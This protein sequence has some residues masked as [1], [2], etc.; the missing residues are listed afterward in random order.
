MSLSPSDL[1]PE[2]SPWD[3]Y[4]DRSRFLGKLPGNRK[5][6]KL[7][8]RLLRVRSNRFYMYSVQCQMTLLVNGGEGGGGGYTI[9]YILNRPLPTGAFQGQ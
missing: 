6:E 8:N 2:S 9:Q 5:Q 3:E 7:I 4:F 1:S